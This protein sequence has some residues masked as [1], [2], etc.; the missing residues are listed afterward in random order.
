MSDRVKASII[1]LGLALILFTA[2]LCARAQYPEQPPPAAVRLMHTGTI[3]NEAKLKA[4]QNYKDFGC[5]DVSSR[6]VDE[7]HSIVWCVEVIIGE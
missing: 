2:L 6:S 5:Q 4:E 3:P 1:F 7:S